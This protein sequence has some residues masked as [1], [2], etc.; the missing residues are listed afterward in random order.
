M[1]N[2]SSPVPWKLSW[3]TN[4]SKIGKGYDSAKEAQH[5]PHSNIFQNINQQ[6]LKTN[7]SAM[8]VAEPSIPVLNQN[9]CISYEFQ[10]FFWKLFRYASPRAHCVSSY[11]SEA[12]N[13]KASAD[14]ST[15]TLSD[16][17]DDGYRKGLLVRK[18]QNLLASSQWHQ[19]WQ[20]ICRAHVCC[21]EKEWLV[22]THISNITQGTHGSWSIFDLF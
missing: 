14:A 5:W 3:S 11:K 9:S 6:D 10:W 18:P 8:N 22:L 12:P 7:D 17:C 4:E 2:L 21:A 13:L 1:K 16:Q 20:N 15:A 19:A